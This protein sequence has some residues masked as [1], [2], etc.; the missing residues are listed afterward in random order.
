MRHAW[1]KS[2][3]YIVVG[4]IVFPV[5]GQQN[6]QEWKKDVESM[7]YEFMQCKEVIDD[8]SPCN[9]F[10]GKALKRIYSIDDFERPNQ[11]SQFLT[12]NEVA[13]Y[14][15]TSDKWTLLGPASS[16]EVLN[17]AQGYANVKKAVIAVLPAQ[18]YGHVAIVLPGN[19]EES[20]Q[21]G[22]LKVPNSASFFLNRPQKSYIGKKLSFAFS[23]PDGVKIYGRNF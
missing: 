14:V 4:L 2:F 21:W 20:Q 7:L 11:P 18:P 19:L 15:T 17:E 13:T 12:A 6:E 8:I 10:L 16:Q 5:F 9:H 1:I 22:G 3:V 23:T